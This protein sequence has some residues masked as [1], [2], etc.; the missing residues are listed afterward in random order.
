MITD[1]VKGDLTTGR[2]E[3]NIMVKTVIDERT[4]IGKIIVI[5][6]S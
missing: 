6:G 4:R 3:Q 1:G 5:N 2:M